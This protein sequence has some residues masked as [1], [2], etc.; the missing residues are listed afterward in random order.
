[1]AV[2]K[3]RHSKRVSRLK[4]AVWKSK[5]LTAVNSVIFKKR[6]Q[7]FKTQTKCKWKSLNY[8]NTP[9]N[10]INFYSYDYC[11]EKNI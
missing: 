7:E 1:M 2:P 8:T 9:Y 11:K 10:L 3:K 6:I 4:Q 5:L